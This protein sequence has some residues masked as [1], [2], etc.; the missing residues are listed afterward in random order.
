VYIS[1][2]AYIYRIY[3]YIDTYAY[4]YIYALGSR[5]FFRALSSACPFFFPKLHKITIYIYIYIY[6]NMLILIALPLRWC[7]TWLILVWRD[8]SI[9][10]RMC[11]FFLNLVACPLVDMWHVSFMC[12]T[13]NSYIY[14]YIYIYIHICAYTYIYVSKL[15]KGLFSLTLVALPLGWC[16]TWLIDVCVTWLIDVWHDSLMCDMTQWCM[17]WLIHICVSLFCVWLHIAH[18]SLQFISLDLIACPSANVWHDS[19]IC[20]HVF[21]YMYIY[22]YISMY[23]YLCICVLTSDRSLLAQPHCLHLG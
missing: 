9:C 1:I 16:V 5:I 14:I 21:I 8:S 2:N 15:F 10:V 18:V 19:F 20:I 6:I 23:I 11:I 7:V 12:N 17:T 22:I 13:T 3:V 4:I